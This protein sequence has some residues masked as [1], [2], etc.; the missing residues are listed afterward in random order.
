MSVKVERGVSLT[1]GSPTKVLD[2]P[3]VWTLPAFGGR[4][5]DVSAD[6]ERFLMLK[7]AASGD[8]R[9]GPIGVTVVQNWLEELKGQVPAN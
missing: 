5:Y 4:L 6:G 3:Y 2:G 1:V 8:S 7:D 9:P